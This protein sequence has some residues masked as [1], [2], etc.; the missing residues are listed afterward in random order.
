MSVL[1]LQRTKADCGVAALRAAL[2]FF[3]VKASYKT[4]YKLAETSRIQGTD[5]KNVLKVLE[6]YKLNFEVRT[7]FNNKVAY[8]Q[9]TE[10]KYINIL[11]VDQ[12]DHWVVKVGGHGNLT[13]IFD[14][15]VGTRVMT[16]RQLL[17]RWAT[18]NGETYAIGIWSAQ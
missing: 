1:E 12:F 8:K 7:T 10:S 11:C 17:K 9:L 4:I 14:P 2:L 3:G 15:E 16:K 6:H 13:I 5:S 18:S